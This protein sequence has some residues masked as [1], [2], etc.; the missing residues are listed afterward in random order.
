MR[1]LVGQVVTY[2]LGAI[3]VVGA[4]L[5]AKLRSA[6]TV[7]TTEAAL[8]RPLEPAPGQRFEW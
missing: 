7:I 6:Q 2:T 1:H 5:F 3:L 4:A 8:L